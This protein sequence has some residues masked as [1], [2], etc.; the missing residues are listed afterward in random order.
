LRETKKDWDLP[1]LRVASRTFA[2]VSSVS[3][4]R[5]GIVNGRRSR[6]ASRESFRRDT[7]ELL[8]DRDFSWKI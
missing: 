1:G 5:V 2:T 7:G 3:L 6:R 8:A 4:A